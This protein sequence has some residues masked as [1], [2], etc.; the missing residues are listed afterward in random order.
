ME[1]IE[2]HQPNLISKFMKEIWPR[3]R[4]DAYRALYRTYHPS[5]YSDS[6]AS[7]TE[8]FG[9]AEHTINMAESDGLKLGLLDDTLNKEYPTVDMNITHATT[10]N[11]RAIAAVLLFDG[12]YD[13]VEEFRC[14]CGENGIEKKIKKTL[15][16]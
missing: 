11:V 1:K 9:D 16:G 10:G 15:F 7:P 12:F 2:T 14:Y 8:H 5:T 3:Y 4:D 6:F 13:I